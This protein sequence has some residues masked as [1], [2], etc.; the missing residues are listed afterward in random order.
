MNVEGKYLSP[1]FL[2]GHVHIDDSMAT[3]SEFAKVVIPRGTTG[4]FMDPH[5]IANVLGLEGV[6]LI[7]EEAKN[8]PL[9]V[10]TTIP[11]CVPATSS[12]FETAGAEFGR[13]EI[14]EAMQWEGSI[15]LGEMM[16]YPGVIFGEDVPH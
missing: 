1:G 14:K 9:R 8:V 13:E 4:V 11:S 5:E 10:Y 12:R 15:A 2:D 16:N 6:K 7:M 3:V